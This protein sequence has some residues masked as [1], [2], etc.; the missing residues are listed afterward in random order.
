MKL[1]D[2]V[3]DS[4]ARPL[5][6][7][8]WI[9]SL[10]DA[11]YGPATGLGSKAG[12]LARLRRAGYPV[13]PGFVV[14]PAAYAAFAAAQP[15]RD[16]PALA[17]GVMPAPLLEKLS[18]AYA[19]LETH[20]PPV[21]VRSSGALEDLADSS[22]AGQYDTVLGVVG[23]EALA[24][25]VQACWASAAAPHVQSYAARHGLVP[26][27]AQMSVLVQLLVA[28]E[29]AGVAFGVDPVT[30]DPSRCVINA[31]L[32]LGESV[33]SGTVIPDAYTVNWLT[34][35]V[36]AELGDKDQ[37][38]VFRD[39]RL[40]TVPTTPEERARPAL[41]PEAVQQV[42]RLVAALQEDAGRPMDVEFAWMA[43]RLYLLQARP[44]TAMAAEAT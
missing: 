24:A 8:R 5:D 20:C 21:A 33:V 7:D 6:H 4:V 16:A 3:T 28:A 29:A 40:A 11:A 18:D 15:A 42:A 30:G 41:P 43:G 39:G 38:V 10:D 27:V 23:T 19:A 14:T 31:S 44:I 22:F 34:G 1:T 13:P 32:G 2:G 9:V 37:Q 35:A 17:G 26:T 25:A 36:A 12:E